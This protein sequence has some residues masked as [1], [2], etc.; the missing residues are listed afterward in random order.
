MKNNLQ[1]LTLVIIALFVVVLVVHQMA[2]AQTAD[3][4]TTV[5]DQAVSY[6]HRLLSIITVCTDQM[7]IDYTMVQPCSNI[8]SHFNSHMQR[9]FTEEQ[10][11]IQKIILGNVTGR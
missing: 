11:D 6:M 7:K 4:P 8:V 3:I 5:A 2:N 1:T 9:M 10:E